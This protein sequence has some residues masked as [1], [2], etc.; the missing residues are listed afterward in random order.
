MRNVVFTAIVGLALAA[1][2]AFAKSAKK[3]TVR[4]M[5]DQTFVTKAAAGG[6]AEV[7][8]GKLAQEKGASQQV[9]SFGKRMVDDHS[10]ANDELKALAK[11]KNIT[12]P[13]DL[14]THDRAEHDR[15]AKLSGAAFD[16]AYMRA[17]LTDH[18]EDVNEFRHESTTGKDTDI[19][20]FASKTLPTL[21]DH[22]K[23]AQ[24]TNRAVGTSG[25]AKS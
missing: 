21:E 11:S 9:K 25:K 19:K 4:P 12:L 15:L 17:M 1:T 13:A 18:R 22:L 5:S 16:R 8:L 24:D 14:D 10:R 3:P 7:D 20:A 2:P 23:M 6:L